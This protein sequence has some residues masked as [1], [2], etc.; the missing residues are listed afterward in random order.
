MRSLA[1]VLLFISASFG[2]YPLKL[3]LEKTSYII[4]EPIY[5]KISKT[6]PEQIGFGA[7]EDHLNQFSLVIKEPSNVLYL[8]SPPMGIDRFVNENYTEP[9]KV[10][11]CIISM[12]GR[13]I[14]KMPG[15]YEFWM[16]HSED[17]DARKLSEISPASNK[18]TISI[19]SAQQHD[20]IEA[21]KTIE[22]NQTAYAT[23]LYLKGGDHI[24]EG[25]SIFEKLSDSESSFKAMAKAILSINYCQSFYDIDRKAMREKD[26]NKVNKY[27][28]SENEQ[29]LNSILKLN[30]ADMLL[31]AFKENDIP[32]ALLKRAKT[33]KSE[34]SSNE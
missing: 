24:K 22:S 7:I 8:Y 15:K 10:I 33:I 32:Y 27:F 14:T 6:T 18:L 9:Q 20:D 11:E 30:S 34:N 3:D 4:Y 29:N 31:N 1:I 17:N 13:V 26:M 19:Q 25:L 5:L 12:H 16:I 21:I 28:P 23:F 2:Q